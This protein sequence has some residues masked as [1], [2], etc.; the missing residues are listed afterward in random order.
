VNTP[1][2]D[3][4]FLLSNKDPGYLNAVAGALAYSQQ[5]CNP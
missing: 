1:S 3:S 4:V 5:A 2:F